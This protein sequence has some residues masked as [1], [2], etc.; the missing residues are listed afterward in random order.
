VSQVTQ[1]DTNG[2]T[3]SCSPGTPRDAPQYFY[4]GWSQTLDTYPNWSSGQYYYF[5]LH[6]TTTSTVTSSAVINLPSSQPIVGSPT[7]LVNW[8]QSWAFMHPMGELPPRPAGGADV[9]FNDTWF[10]A[11]A[12]FTQQYDGPTFGRTPR[13]NGNAATLA[14]YD[15]GVANGPIGYD[16]IDYFTT[17]GAQFTSFGATLT[18]PTSGKRYAAYFRTTFNV[19]VGG[20]SKLNLQYL[21][22]DGAI[23]YLDGIALVGIN[24]SAYS[25]FY[26]LLAYNLSIENALQ[27][28]SLEDTS[29]YPSG[30]NYSYIPTFLAEGTH[31]LAVA[32]TNNANNSSDL[33]MALKLTATRPCNLAAT[34]SSLLRSNAGTPADPTDDTWTASISTSSLSTGTWKITSTL[35]SVPYSSA[36]RAIGTPSTV[37]PFP[38]SA[39]PITIHLQHSASTDCTAQVTITPPEWIG[40]SVFAGISRPILRLPP[41]TWSNWNLDETNFLA[42]QSFGTGRSQVLESEIINLASINGP[43][44]LLAEITASEQETTSN[45]E[46]T[47]SLRVQLI[48]NP[49]ASQTIV[50]LLSPYDTN[51]DGILQGSPTPYTTAQDELNLAKQPSSNAIYS[52]FLL[53]YSIPDAITSAKLRIT[54]TNDTPDE[55]F[56]LRRFY[57]TEAATATTD[58][59]HDGTPD[60]DEWKDGTDPN[61]PHSVLRITQVQSQP[62]ATGLTNLRLTLP[63]TQGRYYRL[64]SST[65]LATWTAVSDCPT[66]QG[67]GQDIQF[68]CAQ[69]SDG[70]SYYRVLVKTTDG[71]WAS[72]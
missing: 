65:D 20:V 56:S 71:P 38:V 31:S 72:F 59:D 67:T 6:N 39:G 70:R 57:L 68:P 58:T 9:D 23:I 7:T 5:I 62:A 37:G 60:A 44:Q 1:I 55:T 10:L 12:A 43:V 24:A 61:N 63:S 29:S 14:S 26:T 32:V 34:A 18:R 53:Q 8:N 66:Q 35:P 22:D 3:M 13:V 50:E 46:S 30:V 47:D 69:A 48:L 27:N 42:Q 64:Y 19:P 21:L 36:T 15:S 33:C 2:V 25:H 28:L 51:A 4:S 52:T 17:S 54:T 11:P 49:G 40:Q 45:F 41:T 16:V